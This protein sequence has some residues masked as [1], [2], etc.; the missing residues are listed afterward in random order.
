MR[1]WCRQFSEQP[2]FESDKI[3]GL[4]VESRRLLDLTHESSTA[5]S[6]RLPGL[7]E[8]QVLTPFQNAKL[9]FLQWN[10]QPQRQEHRRGESYHRQIA[11]FK[12]CNLADED[13][14]FKTSLVRIREQG[15]RQSSTSATSGRC[16]A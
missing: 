16:D 5:G 7:V 14:S 13:V 4:L 2:E 3:L 8:E 12:V 10:A 6:Q 11:A 9:R 1:H 15:A